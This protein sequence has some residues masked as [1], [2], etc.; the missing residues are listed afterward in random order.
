MNKG[1]GKNTAVRTRIRAAGGAA[2]GAVC[3]AAALTACGGPPEEP[4][5]RPA[6]AAAPQPL[7]QTA[8]NARAFAPGEQA[9]PY[10]TT[11]YTVSG[12]PP[13]DEYTAAPAL[14]QPLVGLRSAE[15]GPHSQVHRRLAD[16]ARPQGA[17]VAV[18]LR[19]YRPGGA[20]GVMAALR[21]AGEKCKGGFTENRGR[22]GAAPVAARY[23]AVEKLPAPAG[24]GDEAQAYRLAVREV[25]G[26]GTAYEYLT[27]VRTGA[28]TLSFRAETLGTADLGGVPKE[29][30]DAQWEKWAK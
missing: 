13:S 17:D 18:Q 12:S 4:R 15:G 26:T 30:V 10:R 14:C 25:R 6:P 27:V 7:S 8:L 23:T 11:E 1:Y 24:T 3:C 2:L 20:A 5:N 22:A 29:I 16:P 21:T 28:T 19:S 9:G